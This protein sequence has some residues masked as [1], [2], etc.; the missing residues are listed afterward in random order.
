MTLAVATAC[1]ALATATMAPAALA[2]GNADKGAKLHNACLQCHGTELYVP[3][4]AKV[5]T[6]RQLQVETAK[7]GDYYNPRFDKIEIA[8][9]VAWLNR[10]FY[11]FPEDGKK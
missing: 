7:W 3:P 4:K 6:Y 2:L 5:K 1:A 8:D 10:E 11:K 9:L